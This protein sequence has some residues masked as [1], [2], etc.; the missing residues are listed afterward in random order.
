MTPSTHNLTRRNFGKLAGATSMAVAAPQLLLAAKR[1][2]VVVGGGFGGATAA[3]YLKRFDSSLEVTLVEPKRTYHT[4]PFSNLVLGNLKG[5]GELAQHYKTL[6]HKYGIRVIHARAARVKPGVVLLE[7]GVKLPFERAVVAPGIDF[8]FDQMAGYGEFAVEAMPHA[9]QAGEQTSRLRQ[10]LAAM[11]EGGTVIICP[12]ENPY[13]CPPGPYERASLIAHDLR[14]HNPKAKILIL[15]SKEQFSKQQLFMD[16]WQQHY[17]EMIE[18]RQG[19]AG[20]RPLELDVRG[21][22]VRTEFGWEYGDVINFIPAQQAGKVVRISGL[23]D[24]SGWCPVHAETFESRHLPNVHL[25]GDASLAGAMPKSGFAANSQAKVTAATVVAHLRQE[26]P[27]PPSYLN[28]CYSFV[29][30]GHAI[31]VAGVYRVENSE[32][33]SVK[34]AGGVSPKDA[35]ESLRAR[36]AAYA[37]SWYENITTDVFG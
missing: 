28:I 9:W 3:K 12:P 11:P 22:R 6:E 21:M 23:A 29:T 20:G 33:V 19:S 36:E 10:Q 31:S 8:R 26:S 25:L 35:P 14:H 16:G 4:C 34:G 37:Q 32:I 1:R 7:D 27:V 30:P 17:G 2:V 13:R 15:D 5:F 18:W 24:E